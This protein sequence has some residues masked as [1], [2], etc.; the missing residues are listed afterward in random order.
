MADSANEYAGI[1]KEAAD[2]AQESAGDAQSYAT[3]AYNSATQALNQ[4]SVVEDVVGVLDLISKN[5]DYQLTQDAAVQENKWYFVRSGSGT[6]ADPYVY[7]V[8]V[9]ADDADPSSLGYYELVGIDQAIQNYVSSHLT[10]SG[11]SLFLQNGDTRVELS[12]TEGMILYNE[13]GDPVAKYGTDT[14]IGNINNFGIKIGESPESTQQT[15]VYELGFYQ[16]GN[17]VAYINNNSLYIT[18]TVV[19]KQMQ[20]GDT[21]GVWAWCIHEVSNKNNLYLKWLG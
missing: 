20:M 1:A 3:N 13:N 4:L 19:L 6:E 12:T 8:V 16:N 9:P 14:I 21:L 2:N 18:Q 5:G 10:L 15:P 17:R 7:E 11:N